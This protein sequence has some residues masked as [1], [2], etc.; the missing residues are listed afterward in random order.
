MSW[1]YLNKDKFS[2]ERILCVID[3]P[4][5]TEK[6][7]LNMENNKYTFRVAKDATK[8]EIKEAVE[9]LFNVKVEAVNTLITKGKVKRFKGV[10]GKRASYKKAVVSLAAGQTIDTS[11]GV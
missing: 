6:A 2:S 1:K 11:A 4:V 5:V 10:V 9:T 3:S 7:T 8:F